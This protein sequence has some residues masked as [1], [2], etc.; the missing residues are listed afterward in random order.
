MLNICSLNF[1]ILL[2]NQVKSELNVNIIFIAV[3]LFSFNFKKIDEIKFYFSFY[4]IGYFSN[5][6]AEFLKCISKNDIFHLERS[7]GW[8][9][10]DNYDKYLR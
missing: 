6:L 7:D 8:R 5:I 2:Y 9:Y 1:V 10:L 3:F 4:W